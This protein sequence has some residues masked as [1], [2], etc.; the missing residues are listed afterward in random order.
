MTLPTLLQTMLT[1]AE[2]TLSSFPAL[3][4]TGIL[5]TIKEATQKK[6][7]TK[8]SI[9][10]YRSCPVVEDVLD[11]RLHQF[12]RIRSLIDFFRTQLDSFGR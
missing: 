8:H 6:T 9:K 12:N 2:Y 3:L 11:L 5:M 1:S 10:D 7:K 4:S